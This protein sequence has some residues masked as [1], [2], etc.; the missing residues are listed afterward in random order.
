MNGMSMTENRIAS[1]K[2][3]VFTKLLAIT[4]MIKAVIK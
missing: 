4:K 1:W 3:F 2:F